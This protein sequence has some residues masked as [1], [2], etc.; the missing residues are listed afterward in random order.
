M[1]WGTWERY[2]AQT[3]ATKLPAMFFAVALSNGMRSSK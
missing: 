3:P 2:P 1:L